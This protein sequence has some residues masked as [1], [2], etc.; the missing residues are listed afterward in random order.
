MA[1]EANGR[2]RGLARDQLVYQAPPLGQ[3]PVL[4]VV[5]VRVT[6]APDLVMVNLLPDAEL[7]TIV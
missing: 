1:W 6:V 3:A 2:A 5:Q 7:P 4:V